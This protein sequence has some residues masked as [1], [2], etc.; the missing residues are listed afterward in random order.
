[1]VQNKVQ[2]IEVCKHM[3]SVLVEDKSTL[4]GVK[5]EKYICEAYDGI[6]CPC[7]KPINDDG[8]IDQELCEKKKLNKI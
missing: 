5:I 1:M 8:W 3:Y 2:Q 6:E 7:H 4:F